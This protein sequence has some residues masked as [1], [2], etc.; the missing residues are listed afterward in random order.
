MFDI[1]K[2]KDCRAGMRSADMLEFS[3]RSIIG[4]IIRYKT[5]YDVNHSA[6]I[7][8]CDEYDRIFT[9]EA[10]SLG[11]DIHILSTRLKEFD[12]SVYWYPLKQEYDKYRYDIMHWA[13]NQ[14]DKKYDYPS[15]FANIVSKVNVDSRLYFCSEYVQAGYKK[16]G[17]IKT[18]K[19]I[20]PGGFAKYNLHYNRIKIL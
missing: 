4:G 7:F 9:L 14:I 15:L 16:P 8:R 12:G 6:F 10:L 5:G 18:E 2:Y 19:A 17:M 3:S 11:I 1:D 13:L 20:V